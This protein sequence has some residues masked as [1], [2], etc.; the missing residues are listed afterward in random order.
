M[1]GGYP[2]LRV[3]ARAYLHP[4]FEVEY[5]DAGAAVDDFLAEEPTWAPQVPAEVND[6]L[7]A[8]ADE[9]ATRT[10]VL[11]E[12]DSQYLVEHD[13]LTYRGWLRQVGEAARARTAG[14]PQPGETT[15]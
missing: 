4:D 10:F 1:I 9:T 13:G 8:C 15:T 5:A 3:L 7:A 6:A 12:L 14:G 11:D 2:A